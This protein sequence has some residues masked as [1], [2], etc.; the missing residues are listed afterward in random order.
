MARPKSFIKRLAIDEAKRSHNCQHNK[1]H[2]I[3]KGDIRLGLKGDRST[4]YYCKE[5][6]IEFLKDSSNQIF[7]LI[8]QLKNN[9]LQ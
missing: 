1:Q 3:S 2:R 4:E 9:N 7:K 8:E 5:C 6:S